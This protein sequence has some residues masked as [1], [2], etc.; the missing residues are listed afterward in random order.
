MLQVAKVQGGGAPEGT[1][2]KPGHEGS[3]IQPAKNRQGHAKAQEILRERDKT[4]HSC[5][6]KTSHN[7]SQAN[8]LM[9]RDKLTVRTQI[10]YKRGPR[11]SPAAPLESELRLAQNAGSGGA[12]GC[13]PLPCW[14]C[15]P[16]TE[17]ISSSENTWA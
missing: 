3:P 10:A 14:T 11:T 4:L 16:N 5:Q 17:L 6:S 1:P 9:E 8:T 15:M 13:G 2:V 7:S 12:T